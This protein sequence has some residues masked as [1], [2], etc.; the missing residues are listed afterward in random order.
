MHKSMAHINT[1]VSIGWGMTYL[2]PNG[3]LKITNNFT[4]V[5]ENWVARFYYKDNNGNIY[6]KQAGGEGRN[7]C[8]DINNNTEVVRKYGFLLRNE[9]ENIDDTR[10]EIKKVHPVL[11]KMLSNGKRS[12]VLT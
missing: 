2:T 4:E 9:L 7:L 1:S 5:P 3:Y 10:Q 8:I 11:E 6:L 12:I